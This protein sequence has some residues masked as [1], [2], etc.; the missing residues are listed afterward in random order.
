MGDNAATLNDIA[1]AAVAVGEDGDQAIVDAIL[2]DLDTT[3]PEAPNVANA[4]F[5]EAVVQNWGAHP[6]TLGAYSYPK[7]GTYTTASDNKRADLQVPVANNRIFFAGEGTHVTHPATVVGAL[8]EGERAANNVHAVNG[9]PNNPPPLPGATTMSVA[10]ILAQVI[11]EGG[12]Q[13]RPRATVTIIDN[14]GDP[15]GSATVTGEFTGSAADPSESELTNGSGMAV[16]N[17][18]S[19]KKG[20]V[21]FTF[22]VTNV[23]HASLTYQSGDNAVDCASK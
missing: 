10:S 11:G 5:E 17:S 8:H 21:K 6:Y 12:G 4:N 9:S 13:K 22:C 14:Q 18:D 20:K 3:F 16:L 2:F 1:E 23:T 15:A 7:V 19:T